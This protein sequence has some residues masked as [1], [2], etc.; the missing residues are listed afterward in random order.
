MTLP[1]GWQSVK[2][3]TSL[4]C[5]PLENTQPREID[6][7]FS[8]NSGVY[9]FWLLSQARNSESD[10]LLFRVENSAG[11][12]IAGGRAAVPA[13]LSRE[14]MRREYTTGDLLTIHLPDRGVNRPILPADDGDQIV[15][16][17]NHLTR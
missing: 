5:I 15:V 2:T 6:I 4:S 11:D 7:E 8:A 16:D 14:W 13:G 1:H 10:N 12:L 3:S 9:T 17:Q